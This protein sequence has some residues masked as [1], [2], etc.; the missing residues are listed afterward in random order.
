[1]TFSPRDLADSRGCVRLASAHALT[2]YG[3]QGVT[4]ESALVWADAG[5]DRHDAFV[6]VSR[7]RGATR[8][9]VDRAAIDVSS[10][11]RPVGR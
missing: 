2:I 10:G 5:L 3:S 9:F 11:S 8:L 6:A 1:V 7:A 4:T